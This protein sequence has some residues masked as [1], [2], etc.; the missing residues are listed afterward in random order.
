MFSKPWLLLTLFRTDWNTVCRVAYSCLFV[1]SQVNFVWQSAMPYLDVNRVPTSKL[2]KF[3]QEYFDGAC[4][5]D[6]YQFLSEIQESHEIWDIGWC[7]MDSEDSFETQFFG[8][9]LLRIAIGSRNIS[10]FED[11]G[12]RIRDTLFRIVAK[13]GCNTELNAG[14]M[15]DTLLKKTFQLLAYV[16]F[17]TT[18][19]WDSPVRCVVSL[20]LQEIS[21]NYEAQNVTWL[22]TN[23]PNEERRFMNVLLFLSIFMEEFTSANLPFRTRQRVREIILS[24]EPTVFQVFQRLLETQQNEDVVATVI[25]CCSLWVSTLSSTT[26]SVNC[27]A[28]MDPIYRSMSQSS[29]LYLVGLDCIITLLEEGDMGLSSGRSIAHLLDYHVTQLAAFSGVFSDLLMVH[30]QAVQN[31][32]TWEDFTQHEILNKTTLLLLI[33]TEKQ[34]DHLVKRVVSSHGFDSPVHT[35]FRMFLLP[36]TTH[37]HYPRDE[38]VSDLGAQIWFNLLDSPVTLQT[39]AEQSN[40]DE[41][42]LGQIQIKFLDAAFRKAHYPSNLET[43]FCD[44]TFEE[45]EQWYKFRAELGDTFLL[46]YTQKQT[47]LWFSQLPRRLV[48]W[49]NQNDAESLWPELESV[50]FVLVSISEQLSEEVS[51]KNPASCQFLFDALDGVIGLIKDL[52][53]VM[54]SP[55]TRA[56]NVKTVA[57]QFVFCN[58]ISIF[59]EHYVPV[60]CAVQ[61][62]S[63]KNSTPLW[64]SHMFSFTMDWLAKSVNA[65]TY[66]DAKTIMSISTS[67]ALQVFVH[68]FPQIV[69]YADRIL[70]VLTSVICD[71]SLLSITLETYTWQTV[72]MLVPYCPTGLFCQ[73]VDCRLDRLASHFKTHVSESRR[74]N[75]EVVDTDVQRLLR[76]FLEFFR[77]LSQSLTKLKQCD[78]DSIENIAQARDYAL[79]VLSGLTIG[80]SFTADQL[81]RRLDCEFIR[82]FAQILQCAL[83][84]CLAPQSSCESTAIFRERKTSFL[85]QSVQLFINLFSQTPELY[86]SLL[87]ASWI[88][89]EALLMDSDCEYP[90]SVDFQSAQFKDG[91]Q[92]LGVVLRRIDAVVI[93]SASLSL[94]C[95][96]AAILSDCGDSKSVLDHPIS[97]ILMAITAQSITNQIETAAKFLR[98]VLDHKINQLEIP[99]CSCTQDL[100]C[101][102]DYLIGCQSN[103]CWNL[104][105]TVSLAG[106]CL[107]EWSTVECCIQLTQ[108]LVLC[109]NQNGHKALLSTLFTGDLLFQLHAC[110]LLI[111]SKGALPRRLV[112]KYADLYS[113]LS[114]IEPDKQFSLLRSLLGLADGLTTWTSLLSSSSHHRSI[115]NSVLQSVSHATLAERDRFVRIIA[116]A[117]VPLAVLRNSLNIFAN[118]CSCGR[119]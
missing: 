81:S 86:S 39:N 4:G 44:W 18:D 61:S 3:I 25:S 96:E 59:I 49:V 19:W 10:Q 89:V 73:L 99:G 85:S 68:E 24:D 91:I 79:N 119:E 105:F 34:M 72:G 62:A 20:L 21:C 94:E 108:R 5:P 93:Q 64:L 92:L 22:T 98:H 83:P 101:I 111:L 8:I 106:L 50:L 95:P 117:S 32:L 65:N 26:R 77:G 115:H 37:G 33:L 31:G 60:L 114:T 15:T 118:A 80:L 63:L 82:Q 100:F 36:L 57:C 11:G 56:T 107:P 112:N 116:R 43:F 70:G 45:R 7:L 67:K 1:P 6:F 38:C 46:A 113:S 2:K 29:R 110:L 27:V 75:T 23:V 87:E 30:A 28:L 55:A 76:P 102:F 90:T 74:C 51:H 88:I 14:A 41:T 97:P 12:L 48:D 71:A 42:F 84:I 69:N 17:Q 103:P 52:T 54:W 47:E 109:L 58:A 16:I 35:L 9:M 104:C 13:Y 66:R 53:T 40:T 78:A